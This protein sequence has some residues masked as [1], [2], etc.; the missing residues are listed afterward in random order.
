MSG[1]PSAFREGSL[2]LAEPGFRRL[3]AARFVS[4]FG[5]A[6]APVAMAFGVL[7]LT[8]APRMVGWVIAS[9]TAAQVAVQLFGGALA[10]RGSR[11]RM[12]IGGDLLAAAAELALAWLLLRGDA[13]VLWQTAL[14][15]H[16]APE[17]LSRV[18][19]YDILGSIALAPLGEA[20]AG[21]LVE[22]LG[23][24]TTL[25]WGVGFIVVPT[26]LVLTVPEVRQLRSGHTL[27]AEET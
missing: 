10:D 5:S 6:M 27:A 16:V 15:T 1:P 11:K 20:V 25:A 9:Q 2:L 24:G 3:F 8:D 21:P 7:E 18:S 13:P 14:H 12:M 26:L 4:A 22:A 23:A 19:A 17:A